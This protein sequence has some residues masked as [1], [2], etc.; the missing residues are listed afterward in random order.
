MKK[1]KVSILIFLIV[2]V[3]A[4]GGYLLYPVIVRERIAKQEIEVPV[5]EE[6]PKK[7]LVPLKE[8][9]PVEVKYTYKVTTLIG[10]EY[11]AYAKKAFQKAKESI[12]ISMFFAIPGKE[13]THPV[14]ILV[15]ELIAAQ[16]RGVKIT[17]LLDRPASKDQVYTAHWKLVER[18]K[19]EGIDAKLDSFNIKNHD[20]LIVIDDR[21]I[22][23]GAHNW[24]E[25]GLYKNI[26][27][28]VLLEASPPN[29]VFR[30]YIQ[31]T[32]KE[33]VHY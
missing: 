16:K 17:F 30:E 28:A 24:T 11:V 19:K 20:K 2:A 23:I 12:Y 22:I 1:W 7:R 10:E 26:E 9:R 25:P 6:L 18:L 31:R 14:N 29:P 21:L 8:E 3:L 33:Q 32:I 4:T 13:A 27:A 5:R 15:N